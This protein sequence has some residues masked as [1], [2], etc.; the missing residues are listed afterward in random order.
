MTVSMFLLL[1]SELLN[2]M[3]I[4]GQKDSYKLGLSIF[5]GVYSLI[6]VSL[7]IYF[8]RK[9]LR[10]SAIVIFGI[11]LVKLFIYDIEDLGTLSKTAVFVSL[12]VLML[13][14]SFLYHKYKGLIAESDAKAFEEKS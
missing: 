7:G 9:H 14:V 13:L 12:G 10:I 8:G 1:S 3:D 4:F 5:W 6:L 11:T 2:W